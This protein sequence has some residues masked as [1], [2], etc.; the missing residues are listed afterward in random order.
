MM[1]S[2][3]V[4]IMICLKCHKLS[5]IDI[6][7]ASLVFSDDQIFILAEDDEKMII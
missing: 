2:S 7:P 3:V 1:M 6:V 4:V 5:S